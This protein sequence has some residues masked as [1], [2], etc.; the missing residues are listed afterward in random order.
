MS[1]PMSS[2]VIHSAPLVHRDPSAATAWR[3][4]LWLYGLSL[5]L[6]LALCASTAGSMVAIWWRS[7]TFAHGFLIVPITLYLVWQQRDELLRLQ[8]RVS[9]WGM[10]ALALWSLAW[11]LGSLVDVQV[12]EQLG[13]VGMIISLTWAL[14][15]TQVL[16]T[17]MFPLG[18]LFFMVPIGEF[19][20]P[21]M[22]EFTAHFSVRMIQLTGI[23]VYADGFFISLPSGDWSIVE[24]CSGV[25]Y[26]I[27]SVAVG[28]LYAYMF[29]HNWWRRA[30]FMLL[31]IVTPIIANGL[32]AFMIIMIGHFSGMKLATGVDHLIY[33]WVFFGLVVMLMFWIGSFWWDRE[34][35]SEP[36]TALTDAE[37]QAGARSYW[38]GLPLVLLLLLAA[39][40]AMQVAR[41]GSA[42]TTPQIPVPQALGGWTLVDAPLSTW[43]PD[44]KGPTATRLASYRRDGAQVD[45]ELFDY[46]DQSQGAELVNSQNIL[47]RQKHPIWQMRSAGPTQITLNGA[48][49]GATQSVLNS[50]AL[51]LLTWEWYWIDGHVTSNDYI[52]KALEA[53]ARITDPG[54]GGFAL[55]LSTPIEE[56]D[57][58]GH[59]RLQSFVDAMWPALETS[60][61]DTH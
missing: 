15:G 50:R 44:Y 39:P 31:A 58:R 33:G 43:Q 11:L 40:V 22:M 51:R 26:I 56:Q 6:L 25:R 53:M 54:R 61:R 30:A 1:N 27:A 3:T 24:G 23:P 19:L 60:M 29:Y 12:V 16:R 32:R 41:S 13:L 37:Q 46:R 47:I 9:G 5:L 4:P 48:S 49:T 59:Q 34:P 14:L 45:V 8:P 10:V 2:E 17:I 21:P 42:G 7:E 36:A 38:W 28:A 52:A 35:E 55:V 20:I 57:K 18:F